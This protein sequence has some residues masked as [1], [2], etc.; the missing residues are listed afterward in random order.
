[1]QKK[2]ALTIIGGGIPG[3]SLALMLSRSTTH[4]IA[5]VDAKSFRKKQKQV[6]NQRVSAITPTSEKILHNIGAWTDIKAKATPF[7][8]IE[9]AEKSA[10]NLLS[11]DAEQIGLYY[12]GHIIANDDIQ[13]EL[14]LKAEQFPAI[15][16]FEEVQVTNIKWHEK[17]YVIELTNGEI[18]QTDFLIGADGQNSVCREFLKIPIKQLD[19]HQYAITS[20]IQMNKAHE[21]IARQIFLPNGPLGLLPL[22]DPNT[23]SIVLSQDENIATRLMKL[24]DAAF[25]AELSDIIIPSWGMVQEIGPRQMFPLRRL[26][27][28]THIRERFVLLGDAAH[29]VHPLAGQGLNMN[30]T[31]AFYL[32]ELLIKKHAHTLEN[33]SFRELRAYERATK[34]R[35]AP[36]IF[37][38]DALKKIFAS[39]RLQSPR[40]LGLKSL[41]H[42]S[43]LKKFIMQQVL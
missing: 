19:Y 39:E 30:L 13:N 33:L 12:L 2:F 29:T 11:F 25:K 18:I 14:L 10:A 21:N 34:A 26:L 9:I 7:S 41:Q 20:T 35:N 32:A 23:Y 27:A 4:N 15:N 6:A 28:Q 16:W 36:I 22:E 42:I 38:I 1:M 31:D 3:L 40:R 43:F 8:K 17:N 24:N 5:I 37:A